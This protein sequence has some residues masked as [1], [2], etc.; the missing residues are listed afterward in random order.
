MHNFQTK[1]Q[2]YLPT[3]YAKNQFGEFIVIGVNSKRLSTLTINL[4]IWRTQKMHTTHIENPM[5][6]S[7]VSLQS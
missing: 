2:N 1:L 4:H 5:K 6:I 3:Y 7:L